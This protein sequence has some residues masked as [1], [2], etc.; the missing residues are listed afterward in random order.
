MFSVRKKSKRYEGARKK[1][2]KQEKHTNILSQFAIVLQVAPVS[3]DPTQ[4]RLPG[5][6][7]LLR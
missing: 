2:T 6:Y 5:M 4:G 7:L 3:G 1:N